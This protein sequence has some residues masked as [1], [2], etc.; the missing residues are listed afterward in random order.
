MAAL[1]M[2]GGAQSAAARASLTDAQLVFCLAREH[3]A[4][5][6]GAAGALG[7][8]TADSR[9]G[10]IVLAR[11][12]AARQWSA[13]VKGRPADFERACTALVDASALDQAAPSDSGK[14]AFLEWF[15]PLLVGAGLTWAATEYRSARDRGQSA[16]NEIRAVSGAFRAAVG[17]YASAWVGT[18][19]G[20]APSLS[21]LDQARRTLA[22]TLARTTGHRKRWSFARRFLDDL[23]GPRYRV[24]IAE[25][26]HGRNEQEKQARAEHVE[27]LLRAFDTDTELLASAVQSLSVVKRRRM[28]TR[29]P[30]STGVSLT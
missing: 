6:V 20:P 29:T 30:A 10:H 23:H 1:L 28:R 21:A 9:P 5:L 22:A 11:G 18:T 17:D 26:W 27:G 13:W 16:A 15:L 3:R 14:P 25:G 2:G 7:L 12:G 8:V 4:E 24:E 19:V